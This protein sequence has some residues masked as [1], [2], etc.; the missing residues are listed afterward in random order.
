MWGEIAYP[1]LK[2]LSTFY[3]GYKYLSMLGLNLSHVSKRA[4]SLLSPNQIEADNYL[5]SKNISKFIVK[6]IGKIILDDLYIEVNRHDEA[7]RE[8]DFLRWYIFKIHCIFLNEKGLRKISTF[9]L[10][11]FQ[12]LLHFPEWKS[13]IW[14]EFNRCLLIKF[15]LAQ[16]QHW[17]R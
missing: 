12:N 4:S 15:Q 6:S 7:R 14:F 17:F 13:P 10:V 8:V 16:Y 11:H 2:F 3:N 1:F 9:S 5:I